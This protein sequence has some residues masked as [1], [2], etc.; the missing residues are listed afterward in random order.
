[1]GPEGPTSPGLAQLI[2]A[3]PYAVNE[4]GGQIGGTGILEVYSI[5]AATTVQPAAVPTAT[6][7]RLSAPYV[8]AYESATPLVGDHS[9]YR[10][11]YVEHQSSGNYG[12]AGAL[13]PVA[14]WANVNIGCRK[15]TGAGNWAFILRG[16]VE[17]YLVTSFGN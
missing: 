2:G 8:V 1:M 6:H 13:L 16:Y 7:F 17:Y 3:Y 5:A 10:E 4:P 9:E 12:A 11:G 14:E 15:Q